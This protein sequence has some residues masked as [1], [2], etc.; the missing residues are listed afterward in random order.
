MGP[1][2]KILVA[3]TNPGKV[4]E[5]RSMLDENVAWVSLAEFPEAPE[6]VEDGRTFEENA[7]KKALEYSKATGLWTLAD[8]SGLV[9]DY[10]DGEPGVRSARY[11][12]PVPQAN[13][14]GLIDYR[15]IEKVLG[16]MRGVPEKQR[17][18]RFVCSLCLATR[19]KVL[20]QTTGTVEGFITEKQTGSGGFG[21]DPI[22]Y[23]PGAKL[24]MAQM[25]PE[26]KNE[27]SHRRRA[28]EQLKPALEALLATL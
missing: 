4:A 5:L 13:A 8:D 22:F 26:Q 6:V 12:G 9:I 14:R 11:S 17:S 2:H 27:I 25:R 28:I 16:K 18:A 10:L 20:A 21:Y 23:V 1:F 3:T 19:E 15:N 24:T 7:R